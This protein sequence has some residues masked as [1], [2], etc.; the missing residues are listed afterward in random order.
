MTSA[1]FNSSSCAN[2]CSRQQSGYPLNPGE[3]H[4]TFGRDAYCSHLVQLKDGSPL[5]PPIVFQA[6]FVA[7]ANAAGADPKPSILKAIDR[8]CSKIQQRVASRF[9]GEGV[10][11]CLAY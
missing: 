3:V 6:K 9:V 10:R 8:E 1:G 11:L 5:S 7:G 4:R 2:R